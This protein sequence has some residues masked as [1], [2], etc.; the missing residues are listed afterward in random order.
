MTNIVQTHIPNQDIFFKPYTQRFHSFYDHK[1]SKNNFYITPEFGKYTRIVGQDTILEGFDILGHWRNNTSVFIKVS[2]GRAIINNTYVEIHTDNTIAFEQANMF[3]DAGYFV[4]S[5]SF[6]NADSLRKNQARLH[7]TYFDQNNNSFGKFNKEK[8]K[9]ILGIFD[10]TKNQY[11]NITKVSY[12]NNYGDQII[13]DGNNYVVR[14]DITNT[15]STI[16][17][18]GITGI[19]MD[20]LPPGAYLGGN[21]DD[22]ILGVCSPDGNISIL[23]II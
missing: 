13:L 10:F 3:D 5:L 17:N 9:I 22:N 15:P 4:L 18:G 2:K 7:L 14:N 16:I 19:E 23:K 21:S 6:I 12:Y 1:K 11:N 8:D 20:M